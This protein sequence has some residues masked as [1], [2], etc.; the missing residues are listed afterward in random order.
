MFWN[1]QL[2][3]FPGE[4]PRSESDTKTIAIGAERIEVLIADTPEERVLGL[5][6]RK[7]LEGREG[8][9]FVFPEEGYYAF[10]M[11][12]MRFSIDILWLSSDGEVV[13]ITERA[14]P[15]SYPARFVSERPARYVLELP[16]GYVSARGV[17]LGDIVR[18]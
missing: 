15:E 17:M 9:L 1:I 16:A 2:E 4:A 18:L 11:K 6:G 7:M 8:M 13:Y 5:S 12:D 3:N 14:S 10:W